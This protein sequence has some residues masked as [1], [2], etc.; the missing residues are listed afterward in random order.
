MGVDQIFDGQR[1]DLLDGG[2]D[3]VVQR[4]ELAVDHDDAVGADRDRDVAALAFEQIGLVAEIG[5]LDLDLGE[6]DVLLRECGSGEQHGCARKRG[7][8]DAF[9]GV[10]RWG[11]FI[12]RV[13]TRVLMTPA[14][15]RTSI[16]I[17]A[18]ADGIKAAKPW[19]RRLRYISVL[20]AALSQAY[21]LLVRTSRWGGG[22]E[23]Q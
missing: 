3:L 12:T 6:I 20:W 2:L 16:V 9:H 18:P 21:C 11:D 15:K 13:A 14:K 8:C 1:R 23:L 17:V 7:K 10:L 19:K 22:R 4:R 5:G